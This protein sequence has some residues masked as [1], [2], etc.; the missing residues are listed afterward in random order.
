MLCL[1]LYGRNT[2]LGG[3]GLESAASVLDGGCCGSLWVPSYFY[4][5]HKKGSCNEDL[6]S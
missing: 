2:L 6:F 3:A 5:C 1:C 4:V